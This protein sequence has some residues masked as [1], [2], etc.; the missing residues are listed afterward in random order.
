MPHELRVREGD[1]V[2]L[3]RALEPVHAHLPHEGLQVP[4]LE[5]HRQHRLEQLDV[6]DHKRAPVLAPRHLH[7]PALFLPLA[8][9]ACPMQYFRI[10]HMLLNRP[11]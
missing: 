5:E 8:H 10:T 4:V 6:L 3:A 11:T 2:A 7:G 1:C 9:I